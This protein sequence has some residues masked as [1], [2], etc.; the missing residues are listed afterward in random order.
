MSGCKK[1]RKDVLAICILI[2]ILIGGL[3]SLLSGSGRGFYES[4]ETPWFAPPGIVFPIVWTILFVLMGISCYI[5]YEDGYEENKQALVVYGIQLALNFAWSIIFFKYRAFLF[6]FIWLILLWIA[7]VV[8]IA[9]FYKINRCAAYL[10]I[11][12][13]LWVTFAGVLNFAIYQLNPVV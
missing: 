11:P 5:V 7:I 12:Y 10:Q 9:K 8:M 2:P 3:S 6:A 4:V 13:L 1:V